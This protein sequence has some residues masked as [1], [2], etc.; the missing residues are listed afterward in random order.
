MSGQLVVEALVPG[1]VTE[2]PAVV[3]GTDEPARLVT[4]RGHVRVRRH[5]SGIVALRAEQ[6]YPTGFLVPAAPGQ[7]RLPRAV[8]AGLELRYFHDNKDQSYSQGVRNITVRAVADPD[9]GS[10]PRFWVAFEMPQTTEFAELGYRVTV[11]Y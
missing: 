6:T 5:T 7:D 11:V 3:P 4:H 2:V 1:L 8:D 10:A 9:G